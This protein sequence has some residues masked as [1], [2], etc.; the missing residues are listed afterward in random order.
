[1]LFLELGRPLCNFVK[2]FFSAA[3]IFYFIL[4]IKILDPDPH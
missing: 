1:M 3:L 2:I 4:V